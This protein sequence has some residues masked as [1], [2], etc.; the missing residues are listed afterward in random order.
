[1]KN[2]IFFSVL[3]VYNI[4]AAELTSIRVAGRCIVNSAGDTVV[5]HG[6]SFADPDKLYRE[7]R[8]DARIFSEAA[9]WGADVVRFPVLPG[10][11]RSRG[12]EAYLQLLDQGIALAEQHGLYV[13]IAWHSIG[14]LCEGL[15]QNPAY[16]TTLQETKSFWLTIAGR[17]KDRPSVACYELFDEPTASGNTYGATWPL[18]KQILK[19][20]IAEIRTFDSAKVV[21]LSGLNYGYD[22][23]GFKENGFDDTNIAYAVHPFPMKR[24]K[25]WERHWEKDWGFMAD[26]HPVLLTE[27]GFCTAVAEGRCVPFLGHE[28]YGRAITAFC[29]K[30][31]ISWLAWVFDPDWMPPMFLDW[32]FRPTN[33]GRFFKNLLQQQR[34]GR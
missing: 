18:W 27:I 8:W 3:A 10:S 1:M 31:M 12:S 16:E 30:R 13:I 19:E 9:S 34:K 25:P 26:V 22:L 23:T 6:V 29:E 20:L 14:N 28:E 4:A 17:Y 33:Q 5:F 21:L 32:D 7:G 2:L 11:W 15:F 24:E